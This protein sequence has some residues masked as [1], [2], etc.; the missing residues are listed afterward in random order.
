M[1][2][3]G[4]YFVTAPDTNHIGIG[5]LNDVLELVACHHIRKHAKNLIASNCL[6]PDNQTQTR[7]NHC[8]SCGT[9]SR[10]MHT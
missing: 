4:F 7:L 2:Y 6:L 9:D 8:Y 1:K 5:D 3:W 10:S